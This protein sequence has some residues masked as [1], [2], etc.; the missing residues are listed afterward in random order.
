MRHFF[1]FLSL[2]LLPEPVLGDALAG[3]VKIHRDTWG[4]PHLYGDTDAATAF[5]LAYAHAEDD[6]ALLQGVFFAARGEL[7]R[8]KPTKEGF[9]NDYLVGLL[10]LSQ[11]ASEQLAR[12]APRFQALLDGY[13]RGVNY[14][15]KL[16]PKEVHP[17]FTPLSSN[18]VAAN[19]L[20]QMYLFLGAHKPLLQF[21]QQVM[22]SEN[23]SV[24]MPR[25]ATPLGSNFHGVASWRSADGAARLNIN[26]H[27][28]WTG[29]IAWYEAQMI[30]KEGWNM[31]GATFAGSP[32]L[33]LGHNEHLGWA[34]TVNHFDKVDVFQLTS[35]GGAN[36]KYEWDGKWRALKIR[37]LTVP[38]FLPL[39]TTVYDSPYGPTFQ[40]GSRYYS[41]RVV[42]QGRL[43]GALEQWYAMNKARN[44]AEFEKAMERH[45]IPMFNTAYV[46]RNHVS[47][48]Y[49][50]LMPLRP[51][52]YNWSDVVPGNTSRTL[53]KRYLPY[54][55][56]PAVRDP[57][58]GFVQNCNSSPF[59]TTTGTAN[60]KANDFDP[61]FGIETHLTNRALRSLELF[62]QPGPISRGAFYGYKFDQRYSAQSD[63]YAKYLVPFLQSYS[64]RNP[65]E[66]K[67]LAI[68]RQWDRRLGKDSPAL[69]L[70]TVRGFV[71]DAAK[72]KVPDRKKV[73][74][75]FQRAVDKM[76]AQFGDL[77]ATVGAYQRLRRGKVDLPLSG[78]P[79]LIRA[80]DSRVDTD[81]LL[82]AHTGDS[83]VLIVEFYKNRTVSWSVNPF[84]ASNRETSLHYAD[85]APLFAGKRLKPTVRTLAQLKQLGAMG[86]APGESKAP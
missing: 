47:Y 68:L 27:Q 11:K 19:A 2:T 85:Q 20:L 64:P 74:A 30:S 7:W 37:K 71:G 76:V 18:D 3:K 31:T 81:G 70:A 78:G 52:G 60:P 16:H 55:K 4:V 5:G 26:S 80:I 32:V 23:V 83:Y 69:A 9:F 75:S 72:Q 54:Q 35:N 17:R 28:P 24:W 86:Y 41:L 39:P 51:A 33:F 8:L 21:I 15:A 10:N 14:Y 43:L 67:A 44:R 66:K 63:L 25:D 22:P 65:D 42:G 79:D 34:H 49:N 58:T 1:I 6:F 82:R 50:A 62:S 12:S 53:W 84:G 48:V 40:M 57:R 45:A 56:L 36:P 77:N 38:P 13:A 73:E 29:P 61:A 59:Q 46:D